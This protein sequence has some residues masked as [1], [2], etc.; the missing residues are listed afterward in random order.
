MITNR[1]TLHSIFKIFK[2]NLLFHFFNWPLNWL[3]LKI[4]PACI[5]HSKRSFQFLST[6]EEWWLYLSWTLILV[7]CDWLYCCQS[8]E[9]RSLGPEL[10]LSLTS[11][12]PPKKFF[13]TAC[14]SLR[15]SRF[16]SHFSAPF[17][18]T[19]TT[20]L[21]TL[22]TG[23]VVRP[24]A[25]PVCVCVGLYVSVH[26]SDCMLA[27]ICHLYHFLPHQLSSNHTPRARQRQIDLLITFPLPFEL[28]SCSS[29]V[30]IFV[31]FAPYFAHFDSFSL[32][33]L[34]PP[35]SFPPSFHFLLSWFLFVFSAYP[36]PIWSSIGL[37]YFAAGH[38]C[39]RY[40]WKQWR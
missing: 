1:F 17:C 35:W 37:F 7:I 28:S 33:Y 31:H 5:Q 23:A 36:P 10:S 34:Y 27:G 25:G 19:K 32:R 26:Y 8:E 15:H 14:S 21:V 13:V 9:L 16:C 24:T 40:T 38:E 20:N 4:D 12:D 18:V 22:A 11:I 6:C 3:T 2:N 39:K 29:F 30:I